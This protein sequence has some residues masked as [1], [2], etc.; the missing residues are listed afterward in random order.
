MTEEVATTPEGPASAPRVSFFTLGCR[1]NQHDTAAMRGRVL[2]RGFVESREDPACVI[3]NTCT[4]TRRA[5]QEARQLIR[6]IH[7]GSP[8]ARIIVTGC[9]AQ[10]APGE[11]RGLPGVSAVLG[12]AE[13]DQ[14]DTLLRSLVSDRV[15]TAPGRAARTFATPAP[16]HVGRSRALLKIQDGCDSFCT[17][18]VVP[19]VRGRSRSLPPEEALA[20]ARRLLEAGFREIVLTGA[21]LGDYPSLAGLVKTMLALGDRDHRVRLSSIEPNKLDPGL[22]AM[23]ASEPRLCRHLHLP[24]QSGSDRVLRAMRRGYTAESYEDLLSRIT[25]RTTVAIGADVI[26]GFPGEEESDFEE[27]LHLVER[28]PITFLHVFRYSARPGTAAARLPSPLPDE[29]VR[30]RAARLRRL[31]EAKSGAFRRSLVGSTLPVV[32]ERGMGRRGRVAMSDLYVPVELEGVTD[33]TNGILDVRVHDEEG[34]RIVG[35]PV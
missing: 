25:S 29:A 32:M 34:D 2:D 17:Y 19:Y 13:R 1:L 16:F 4:V 26:V 14:E 6:A 30:E 24:L 12:T 3:V 8:G 18:C 27:T 15:E 31:G 22:V 23:L 10:R 28:S 20:R 11:L 5:D 21:D 33:M 9:Y 7:R 35:T